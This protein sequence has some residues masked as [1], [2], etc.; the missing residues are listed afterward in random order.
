MLCALVGDIMFCRY[1]LRCYELRRAPT[2]I[3]L[4]TV[5]SGD[6]TGCYGPAWRYHDVL[7]TGLDVTAVSIGPASS[8]SGI[9]VPPPEAPPARAP[10]PAAK[11]KKA[12]AGVI[13][14]AVLG[15]IA[16]LLLLGAPRLSR[17]Y[18]TQARAQM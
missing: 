15:A 11:G 9:R 1:Y 6:H 13:A 3:K 5:K 16:G 8:A 14:G 12:G 18:G 2:K 17:H 7:H 10:S 4:K